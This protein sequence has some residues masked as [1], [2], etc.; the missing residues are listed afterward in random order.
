MMDLGM[1]PAKECQ[2]I[3]AEQTRVALHH[4]RAEEHRGQ[5]LLCRA[6]SH[7]VQEG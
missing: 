4:V 5:E 7:D 6:L 2:W 3:G 1:G